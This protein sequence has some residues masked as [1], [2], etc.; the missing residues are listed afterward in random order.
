MS[1]KILLSYHS[2]ISKNNNP[3]LNLVIGYPY[4]QSALDKGFVGYRVKDTF[5]NS[6]LVSQ[7]SPDMIGKPIEIGFG[8]NDNGFPEINSIKVSK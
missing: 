8:C 5:A 2:G 7:L 3:Y 4:S 1:K 6:D